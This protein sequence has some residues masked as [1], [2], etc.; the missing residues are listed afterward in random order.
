MRCYLNA[1][2]ANGEGKRP[3]QQH[4]ANSLNNIDFIS[5]FVSGSSLKKLRKWFFLTGF[6]ICIIFLFQDFTLR[7]CLNT[8]YTYFS[9]EHLLQLSFIL[10]LVPLN[11]F[12]EIYKWKILASSVIPEIS[13]GQVADSQLGG[14]SLGSVTPGRV[15]ETAGR[16]LLLPEGKRKSLF[17]LSLN[18]SF[19]IFIA[20]VITALIPFNYYF[21]QPSI[22]IAIC[23]TLSFLIAVFLFP[24]LLEP[25]FKGFSPDGFNLSLF[26]T[27]TQ[28]KVL[29]LSFFRVVIYCVQLSLIFYM[30]KGFTNQTDLFGI[31]AL[32]FGIV[33]M[34]PSLL[35]SELGVRGGAMLVIAG[36]TGVD[37]QYFIAPMGFIWAINVGL[38]AIAG[39]LILLRKFR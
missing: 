23:A 17:F 14:F 5:R 13:W 37:Y 27:K 16:A 33:T 29:F 10:L 20:S 24:G 36:I 31:S 21:N 7:G 39:S 8:L 12:L 1:D 30:S 6:L 15:G 35:I 4:I 18:A 25:L 34:L 22:S 3:Y 2:V 9:S 26:R 11:H 19:S 38:P 28:L 32:Y